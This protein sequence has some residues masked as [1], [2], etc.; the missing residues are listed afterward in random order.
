MPPKPK[1]LAAGAVSAIGGFDPRLKISPL[2][3][4]GT[5]LAEGGAGL[6]LRAL[7]TKWRRPLARRSARR[8]RT[9]NSADLGSPRDFKRRLAFG[10]AQE[11]LRPPSAFK[12]P[13]ARRRRAE[14]GDPRRRQGRERFAFRQQIP[15][16][17]SAPDSLRRCG[18]NRLDFCWSI[19]D[20]YQRRPDKARCWWGETWFGRRRSMG[21]ES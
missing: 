4:L 10:R 5:T 6:G 3:V 11:D 1:A 21:L 12:R 20:K 15:A 18:G 9:T 19:M 7:S 16:P 8:R 13:A 14:A 17:N 2:Q